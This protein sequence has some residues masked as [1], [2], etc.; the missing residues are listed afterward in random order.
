MADIKLNLDMELYQSFLDEDINLEEFLTETF[1]DGGNPMDE[2]DRVSE[3]EVIS[4][5]LKLHSDDGGS[6]ECNEF[7]L[8]DEKYDQE[9]KTGKVSINYNVAYYYS[10]ADMNSEGDYHE[11][12]TFDVDLKKQVVFVHFLDYEKPTTYEEF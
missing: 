3:G 10:C 6:P 1:S 8:T 4:Q 2:F 5:L 7:F 9:S 12:V 11:D